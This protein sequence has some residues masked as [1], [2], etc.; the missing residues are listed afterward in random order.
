MLNW[1]GDRYLLTRLLSPYQVNATGEWGQ[2]ITI[3]DLDSNG[4]LFA[5]TSAQLL[6]DN[7]RTGIDDNHDRAYDPINRSAG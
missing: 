5:G 2:G 4:Q 7:A 1:V 6:I 3:R